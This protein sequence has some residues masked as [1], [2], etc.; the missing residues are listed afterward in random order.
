[1][2]K[3]KHWLVTMAMLLCSVVTIAHDFEVDG[4]YYNITDATNL[5]VEVTYKGSNYSSYKDEYI[6]AVIIPSTISYNGNVYS[7]TSIGNSAFRSCFNLSRVEIPSSITNIGEYAF[8]GCGLRNLEIGNSVTNIGRNAFRGCY[9]LTNIKIPDS[10]INIESNAFY[11]CF[12]LKSIVIGR[13]VTVIGSSAFSSCSNLRTIINLSSLAITKGSTSNGSVAYYAYKVVSNPNAIEGDFVFSIIDGVNTLMAYIGDDTEIVLPDS[14]RGEYYIIGEKAFY[15]N[16][17]ATSFVIP[18]NVISIGEYAFFNCKL[19]ENI[20]IPNSVTNIGD[21]AFRQ[22]SKLKSITLPNTLRSLGYEIFYDCIELESI[23]IPNSITSIEEMAFYNCS[24]LKNVTIGSNVTSIGKY[25]F[26]SCETLEN[27]KMSSSVTKIEECAF[28]GCEALTSIVIPSGVTSL[29][30]RIFEGCKNLKTIINLSSLQFIISSDNN[31]HMP[32]YADIIKIDAPNGSIEGDFVFGIIEGTNTLCGYLGYESEIILPKNY[33]GE[34][35]RIGENAIYNNELVIKVI[36]P[37]GV[38][39][40]GDHAFYGC[41]NLADISI[42][43]SVTNI[44]SWAFGNCSNLKAIIC[45]AK[46]PPII[47]Y[48]VFNNVNKSIPL[49]VPNSSLSTYLSN[50]Y[51]SVFTNIQAITASVTITPYGSATYCS[52]YALDFSEVEGLKAYAATGYNTNT[53]VVTLTRV[54]TSQPGMGLFLKGEPGEYTVPT[55][56]STDDNSL[57]MLVGTQES[58][59]LNGTSTD[60]LYYN[61]RYTIK[62]GDESPLFYRVDDG[63]TLGE[64]KAY[65]QIPVSWMPEE[66]KSVAL[67]YDDEDGVTGIEEIEFKIQNSELI[68]DLMGRKESNP[69]KGMLYVV[70]GKKVVWK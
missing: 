21:Y 19:L 29:G 45:R 66:A 35:Y 70:N 34:G 69:Q 18:D 3:T 56:E 2:R 30:R 58:T 36:I 23:E 6:E 57:N 63:Y 10:V 22:C 38:M 61:Y 11:D 54:M 49:Y 9:L 17:T 48:T 8:Y 20:T 28:S 43:A 26:A 60:G 39:G 1:M 64:G 62:D 59:T 16:L 65:L 67:R 12:G 53:G 31:S 37:N 5:T 13:N 46:M 51:W 24:C 44:A 42:P 50:E 55:L 41:S 32:S 47:D 40:I 15:T 52:E 27:V 33:K 14:Y 68:Y 4:I 7:V 25:A